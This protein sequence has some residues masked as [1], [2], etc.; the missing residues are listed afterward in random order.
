MGGFFDVNYTAVVVASVVSMIMGMVWY[1]KKVFGKQ[2]M[3][4]SGMTDK[5]IEEAKK[6]GMIKIMFMA[7]IATIITSIV[8]ANIIKFMRVSD[9]SG[10]LFAGFLI[11]LGFIATNNLNSVLWENKPFKLYYINTG[12]HLVSMLV[13]GAILGVMI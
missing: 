1:S 7:F 10:G 9:L 4:L 11:W 12:H 3:K 5:K 2:W 13:M 8:L 6:R